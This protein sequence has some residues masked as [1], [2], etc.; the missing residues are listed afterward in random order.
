MSKQGESTVEFWKDPASCL[1]EAK[2][3]KEFEELFPPDVF[4][5]IEEEAEETDNG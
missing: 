4:E 1:D 3:L 5:E 2:L